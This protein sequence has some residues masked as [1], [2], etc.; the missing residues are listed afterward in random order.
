MKAATII[1]VIVLA[2]G[3]GIAVKGDPSRISVIAGPTHEFEPQIHIAPGASTDTAVRA[4][5]NLAK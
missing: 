2:I 4:A 5:R 1:A 3:L